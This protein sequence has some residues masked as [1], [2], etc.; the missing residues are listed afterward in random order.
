ME[1]VVRAVIIFIFLTFALRIVGK[2]VLGEMSGYELILII[3]IPEILSQGLV[4]EDFSIT[5]SIIGA[6]TL[7]TLVM[8]NSFFSYRFKTYRDVLEGEP[9]ILYNNGKFLTENMDKER[10]NVDDILNEIREI[11]FERFS[12]MKWIILESD[13]KI[14]CIP[15]ENNIVNPEHSKIV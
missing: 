5:N 8:V 14:S 12:Q 15:F 10:V 3:L 4:G 9:V 7:L 13:G 11:G 2:R 6:S 1:T